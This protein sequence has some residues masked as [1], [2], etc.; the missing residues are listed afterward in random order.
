[1]VALSGFCSKLVVLH[2]LK[3]RSRQGIVSAL[4]VNP[5][6]V[7]EYQQADANYPPRQVWDIISILRDYDMR[8]KGVKKTGNTTARVRR[9]EMIYKILKRS[10]DSSVGDGCVI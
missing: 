3:D 6:F 8:S 4:K 2:S 7:G 10:E 9:K 5:Y 1:M